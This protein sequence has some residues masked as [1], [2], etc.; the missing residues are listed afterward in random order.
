ML[1][2]TEIRN[3]LYG[4][5]RFLQLDPKAV[6]WF[7]PSW[8]AA[9]R[10][11]W[12]FAILVPM[13]V[14]MCYYSNQIYLAK[15]GVAPAPFLLAHALLPLPF[16]A[17]GFYLAYLLAKW[18]G[19]A[20]HF[21]QLMNAINWFALLSNFVFLP[22][23]FLSE[24]DWLS[25]DAREAVATGYFCLS[26]VYQWFIT[27]RILKLNPFMSAGIS[28]IGGMLVTPVGDLINLH[29]FGIARPFFAP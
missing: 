2:K 14:L 10:S 12:V 11:L 6:S 28:M 5:W 9:L 22:L 16:V 27:W 3:G 26:L 19:A 21:P 20:A 13:G 23:F 29:F 25:R 8:K 15:Y 17:L 24:T 4:A 18:E 1:T 7:D